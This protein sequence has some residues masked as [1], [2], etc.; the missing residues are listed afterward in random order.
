MDVL[1]HE[2]PLSVDQAELMDI[3][4][5]ES[6]RLNERIRMFLAYARPHAIAA[7][8]LDARRVVHDAALLLRNSVDVRETH[9]IAVQVPDQPVPVE[10]D[11]T[12]I[13]QVLWSL[14]TNGLRAMPRGGR[15]TLSCHAEA[16]A[17]GAS[18]VLTVA[19]QGCGIPP[20]ELEVVFQ[21]FRRS[22]SAGAG[23]G[24]AIVHRIVTDHGGHIQVSSSPAGTTVSVRLPA[25]R[26]AA[27]VAPR[28]ASGESVSALRA[29]AL[30]PAPGS[31]ETSRTTAV[32]PSPGSRDQGDLAVPPGSR[33][34][35]RTA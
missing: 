21:P 24:L 35:R 2:L 9:D 25:T 16:P 18:L 27:E 11:E 30:R 10:A 19:D 15:L 3:V 14:G 33:A 6:E 4:L 20:D 29:A 17:D 13:R 26:G 8:A 34:P 5:R 23:L 28:P 31:G 1:R 32:G 7:A 12:E 22:F